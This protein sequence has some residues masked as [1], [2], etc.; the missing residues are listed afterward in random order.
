MHINK[1]ILNHNDHDCQLYEALIMDQIL[2]EPMGSFRSHTAHFKK[3]IF[4]FLLNN[5]L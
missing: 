3:K 4:P 5:I 2:L 1:D